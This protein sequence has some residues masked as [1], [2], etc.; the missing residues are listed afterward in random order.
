K[1]QLSCFRLRTAKKGSELPTYLAGILTVKE[2]KPARR[3]R[4]YFDYLHHAEDEIANDA[5]HEFRASDYKDYRD[6]AAHLPGEKLAA[7]LRDPKI[8][9]DRIGLLALLLG[10]CSKNRNQ[11]A[12]L[13]RKLLDRPDQLWIDGLLEGLMLLQPKTG[14]QETCKVLEDASADF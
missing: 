13:L 11:D 3:L 2:E 6:L 8:S 9:G 12:K 4:F 7:W 5:L 10:H 1:G 14:W